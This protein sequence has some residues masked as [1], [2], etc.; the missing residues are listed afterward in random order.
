MERVAEPAPALASTTSVPASW[1][2]FVRASTSSSVK[3]TS[4][5]VCGCVWYGKTVL[6]QKP[7]FNALQCAVHQTRRRMCQA[8]LVATTLLIEKQPQLNVCSTHT[9]D[10]SGRMVTPAWP[11]MTG[12]STVRRS[13]PFFSATNV[14]ARTMSSVV[15]P[16]RRR[17]SYTPAALS[18]SA[19][20]GMVEFTGF[21]MMWM[22]AW[23]H[24]CLCWCT[25][26]CITK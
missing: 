1:M 8:F 20:M 17:G 26:Q 23:C 24:P 21:E 7:F 19:A 14:L 10:R 6:P 5:L 25:H 9:C 3:R 11:P 16:I 15:T 13:S 22:S 4:G 2:R 12:T 18:T